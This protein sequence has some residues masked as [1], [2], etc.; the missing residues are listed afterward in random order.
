MIFSGKKIGFGLTGSFCTLEKCL[1]QMEKLAFLGADILP[2]L[3][4][5]V[6]STDT[7]FGTAEYFK[8]RIEAITGKKCITRIVDAEPIGPEIHLDLMAVLPCTGNTLAKLANGITDT[9]VTMAI[10]AQLRND[11]PVLLG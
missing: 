11:L 10:K 2:V 7:R 6:S 4:Y 3:S 1:I 9:P 8:K 5:M